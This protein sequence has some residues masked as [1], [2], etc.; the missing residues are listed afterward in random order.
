MLRIDI[1]RNSRTATLRCRGRI[2]FG[3]ENETLRSVLQSRPEQVLEIDLAGIDSMD[4]AGLGLLVELQHW[5]NARNRILYFTNASEFVTRLVFATHLYN[6]LV[7][8]PGGRRVRREAAAS[9]L[10]A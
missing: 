6:V 10:S 9:A 1:Q 8:A 5:A 7:I 4:A 2:V 3:M